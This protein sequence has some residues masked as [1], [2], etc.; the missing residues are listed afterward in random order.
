MTDDDRLCI[1]EVIDSD[2]CSDSKPCSDVS[3]NFFFYYSREESVDKRDVTVVEKS[4]NWIVDLPSV[5]CS[6]QSATLCSNCVSKDIDSFLLFCKQKKE[7][8]LQASER[9]RTHRLSLEY[10]KQ[11][12]NVRKW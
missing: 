8:M 11:N 7:L 12:T 5:A 4:G 3:N 2:S 1:D 9:K 10:I 6:I